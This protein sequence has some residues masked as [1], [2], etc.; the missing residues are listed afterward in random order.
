MNCKLCNLHQKL[1]TGG[2]VVWLEYSDGGAP[3][4]VSEAPGAALGIHAL[5]VEYCPL[6]GA[7]LG[8]EDMKHEE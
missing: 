7:A 8:R 5:R 3:V 6:C 2:L 4:L 1:V